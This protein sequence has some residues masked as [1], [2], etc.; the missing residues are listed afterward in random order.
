LQILGFSFFMHRSISGKIKSGFSLVELLV[1]ISL[2]SIVLIGGF[3]IFNTSQENYLREAGLSKQLQIARSNADTLFIAFHDNT[4]FS[5]TTT[6]QWPADDPATTDNES[7]F[8]LTPLWNN[9]NW[10]DNSS[11]FYCR[12]TALDPIA[13]SFSLAANCY[14]NQGVT[15]AALKTALTK[16][17][18]PN[19][20]LLGASHTCIVT[21]ALTIGGNTV[22]TVMDSNC[23]SDA[24]GV[25]LPTGTEG[26]GAILPRFS[27]D[28]VRKASVISTLFFDHV[29]A[30]RTGAGLYF[31][32]E[33]RWRDN[34]S[35]RYT[36]I[37]STADNFT[38]GWVNIH[39]FGN[40]NALILNNPSA[41]TAMSLQ[42]SVL[43][44]SANGGT[45]SLTANG[46]NNTPSKR[47]YS[48]SADNISA[49]LRSLF[50]NAPAA[51][52]S[53][54]LRFSLNAGQMVWSRD[55]RLKLE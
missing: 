55:L 24:D 23:L 21:D 22:F 20:V 10:L 29:G 2:L 52:D 32:L 9:T 33:D 13:S 50:I 36:I 42:V 28:G 11:D 48:R 54:D 38:N 6:P 18:L 27:M 15:E 39:N 47:F 41:L 40:S 34:N 30:S 26:A 37:G 1:A 5:A 8:T 49:T 31:G 45:L 51:T 25:S 12:L 16:T 43:D 14:T 53:V 17:A 7:T 4:S 19:V 46:V 44:D 35:T 3:A